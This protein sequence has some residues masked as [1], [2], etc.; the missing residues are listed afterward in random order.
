MQQ[1]HL[2][3]RRDPAVVTT[4]STLQNFLTSIV[5]IRMFRPIW[6]ISPE[7]VEMTLRGATSAQEEKNSTSIV[8]DCQVVVYNAYLL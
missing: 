6:G 5:N 4:N 2:D 8:R 7:K 3:A 1:R